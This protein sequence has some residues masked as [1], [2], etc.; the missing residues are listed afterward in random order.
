MLEKIIKPLKIL[1]TL[2]LVVAGYTLGSR[3]CQADEWFTCWRGNYCCKGWGKGKS[4]EEVC[5]QWERSTGWHVDSI[6]ASIEDC[7]RVQANQEC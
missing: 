6:N 3:S 7:E 4:P 5:R 1:S 2:G